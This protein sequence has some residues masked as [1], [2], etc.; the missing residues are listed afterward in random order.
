MASDREAEA[1]EY[2]LRNKSRPDTVIGRPAGRSAYHG[3]SAMRF[4]R[5][6]CD[7]VVQQPKTDDVSQDSNTSKT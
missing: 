6:S 7:R 2:H 3:Q 5:K 4:E 1:E